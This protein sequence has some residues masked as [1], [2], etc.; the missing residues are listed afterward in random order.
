MPR[1][2]PPVDPVVMVQQRGSKL[3]RTLPAAVVKL[4]TPICG[5]KNGGQM[6]GEGARLQAQGGGGSGQ[7]QEI[8]ARMQAQA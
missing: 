3:A 5:H 4:A 8:G 1:R 2:Q 7:G 6:S